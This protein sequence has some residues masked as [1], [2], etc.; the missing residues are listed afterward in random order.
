MRYRLIIAP[1]AQREIKKLPFE[2]GER[3]AARIGAL[4][5]D[6]RP[7]GYKKLKDSD[8]YRIRMSDYRVIYMIQD[9]I[10]TVTIT[11]VA[12]RKDVYR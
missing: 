8:K 6:P 5:D 2:I 10:V 3:V 1:S 4:R 12:H 11:R 9:D 7:P